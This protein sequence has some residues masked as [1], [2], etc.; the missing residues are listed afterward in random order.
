MP[1]CYHDPSISRSKGLIQRFV[2][3]QQ[4]ALPLVAVTTGT[5]SPT[6]ENP[7]SISAMS[8]LC[9]LTTAFQGAQKA[10]AEGELRKVPFC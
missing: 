7:K 5:S 1:T 4:E 2:F 10:V 9:Y 3:H 6:A 8:I